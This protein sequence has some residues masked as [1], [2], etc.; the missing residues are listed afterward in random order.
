LLDRDPRGVS[1]GVQ[2]TGIRVVVAK[3]G[4][5]RLQRSGAQW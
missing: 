1:L 3:V 2:T 5:H 4:V